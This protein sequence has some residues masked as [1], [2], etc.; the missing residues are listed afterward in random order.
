MVKE[1]NGEAKM[2]KTH[3][4]ACGIIHVLGVEKLVACHVQLYQYTIFYYHRMGNS[5]V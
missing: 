2:K 3:I 5:K 1:K 4:V